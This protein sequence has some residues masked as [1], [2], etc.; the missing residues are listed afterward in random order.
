LSDN[1]QRLDLLA[2]FHYVLAGLSGLCAFFPVIHLLVGIALVTDAFGKPQG[3]PP[4]P[5]WAGWIFICV[6]VFAIVFG[7]IYACC[8]A[9][10]GHCLKRRRGYVYCMVIAAISCG[11]IPL[12]TILGVFTLVA[13]SRPGVKELFGRA[14]Q[15]MLEN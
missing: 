9:I 8:L 4:P 2:T 12:G 15:L 3:A 13:L 14:R 6:A 5:T 1:E 7:L 10:A 11:H